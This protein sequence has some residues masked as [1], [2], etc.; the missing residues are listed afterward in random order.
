MSNEA[1]PPQCHAVAPADCKASEPLFTEVPDFEKASKALSAEVSEFVNPSKA[2]SV[3]APE[4][5]P[6]WAGQ[7][8]AMINTAP[9]L[10]L[11]GYSG[12]GMIYGI[13]FDEYSDE[14]DLPPK[15]ELKS[16]AA[17]IVANGKASCAR[18]ANEPS[19]TGV[20]SGTPDK[21]FMTAVVGS[22][23]RQQEASTTRRI[24]PWRSHPVPVAYVSSRSERRRWDIPLGEGSC[25]TPEATAERLVARK[26]PWRRVP[27][28]YDSYVVEVCAPVSIKWQPTQSPALSASTPSTVDSESS[29]VGGG[30][31]LSED[32]SSD[33]TGK[34]D[35]CM[36]EEE[37]L[38]GERAQVKGDN[39]EDDEEEEEEEGKEIEVETE[40]EIAK[41]KEKEVEK[42]R[43]TK[44]EQLREEEWAREEDKA[45]KQHQDNEK[46]TNHGGEQKAEVQTEET[47][48]EDVDEK[49]SIEEFM[50]DEP[51]DEGQFAQEEERNEGADGDLEPIDPRTDQLQLPEVEPRSAAA[52]PGAEDCAPEAEDARADR[53]QEAASATAA[54][55]CVTELLR[56]RHAA[57]TGRDPRAV[58][59]RAA[60]VPAFCAN[61]VKQPPPTQTRWAER[62]PPS[63]KS[64]GALHQTANG[65]KRLS[66]ASGAIS[67][68]QQLK[69]C[70]QSLLNK[71]CPESVHKIAA[72]IK[73]ESKVQNVGELQLVIGLVFRKA[74]A[75][76]HYC[77]SY[78]DLVYYLQTEMPEFLPDGEVK[79]VTFKSALVNVCQEEFE[80]MPRTLAPTSEDVAQ[81]DADELQFKQGQ[82]KARF[83]ANMKLIG[84][85]FLR[86]LLPTRIIACVIQELMMVESA[87][88]PEEHV[89]ECICEVLNAI[90]YTLEQKPLGKSTITQVCGRMLDLKQRKTNG[91]KGIYSKRIQFAIQDILDTRKAG[92]TRKVFKIAAKTKEEIRHEQERQIRAQAAGKDVSVAEVV[93]AG[94]RPAYLDDS[95]TEEV[96]QECTKSKTRCR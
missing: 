49:E 19:A 5:V 86:Q 25:R 59:A 28:Q 82:Q 38:V 53:T 57:P 40:N 1:L 87:D 68:E 55:L 39:E 15:R 26:P 9:N 84:H 8:D 75:E 52:L 33:G 71:I 72:R 76:P 79:P 24:P 67:R 58:H 44:E 20:V 36:S 63:T 77:E 2:L 66:T 45:E 90:G 50:T 51:D 3:D 30:E 4:F 94:Q 17:V 47:D 83:L 80:S 23:A 93:V 92:W 54:T 22:A 88:V 78:A 29:D 95:H 14:E 10:Y 41:G 12:E 48:G 31:S 37:K 27:K 91:G 56:W 74:L 46:E 65:Y 62:E 34:D 70:V 35:F 61:S 73:E 69:R 7:A 85:L 16:T 81:C 64:F 43:G 11:T 60:D 6:C 21:G 13:N 89:V 32:G 42:Q 18:D 96:W